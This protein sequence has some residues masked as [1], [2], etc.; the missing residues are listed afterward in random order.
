MIS[1]LPANLAL[2]LEDLVIPAQEM[3]YVL[4]DLSRSA[5]VSM[6]QQ[7]GQTHIC[8]SSELLVNRELRP[9]HDIDLK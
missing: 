3:E 4:H 2:C 1:L 9:L 8:N 7:S 6:R 5:I